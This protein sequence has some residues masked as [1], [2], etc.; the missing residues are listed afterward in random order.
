MKKLVRHFLLLTVSMNLII[1]AT[2]QKE[3]TINTIP[4]DAALYKIDEG[5]EVKLATGTYTIRLSRD[6]PVTIEVRKKGFAPVRK[7]Y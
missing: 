7:S 5:S 6:K 4:T 1:G 2:A 3:L